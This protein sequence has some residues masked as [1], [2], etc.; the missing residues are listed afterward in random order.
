M[1]D[2]SAY[3]DLLDSLSPLT[4]N[5]IDPDQ[6]RM[7]PAAT[8]AKLLGTDVAAPT[9]GLNR[10]APSNS[11]LHHPPSNRHSHPARPQS[12]PV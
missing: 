6:A 1:A 9:S 4:K 5:G 10:L 11:H 7:D 3:A 2:D 12:H 8:M